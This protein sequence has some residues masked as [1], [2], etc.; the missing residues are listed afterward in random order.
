MAPIT[1]GAEIRRIFAD[2]R[3]LSRGPLTIVGVLS[4]GP[5]RDRSVGLIVGRKFGGAVQ[6]NRIKRRL[7]AIVRTHPE[8]VPSGC[9]LLILPKSS[10]QAWSC[11]TLT[12]ELASLIAAW[13]RPKAPPRAP[14]L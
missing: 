4:G 9:A 5:S 3:R 2:G 12:H 6:R 1:R 7:R 14:R 8:C 11:E 13:A 10:V